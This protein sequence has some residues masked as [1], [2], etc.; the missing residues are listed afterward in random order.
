MPWR[1]RTRSLTS[2]AWDWVPVSGNW[3]ADDAVSATIAL[4]LFIVMLPLYLPAAVMTVVNLIESIAQ[5]IVMP[6]AILLRLMGVL[7]VEVV[8]RDSDGRVH[9]EDVKGWA[10]AKQ[11][12]A[13][14]R[15]HVHNG[16]SLMAAP[17]PP[18]FT[19]ARPTGQP[20]PPSG[21]NPHGAPIGQ[22]HGDPRNLR[23]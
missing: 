7:H 1:S 19:P 11:R 12:Q 6:F 2:R 10:R 15:Q 16:G 17:L 9:R 20:A 22:P 18:G 21:F 3:S 23:R 4:V 14:L 8:A 13:A 5:L